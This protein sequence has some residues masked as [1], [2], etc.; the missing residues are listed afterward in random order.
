M[1]AIDRTERK[2]MS[3]GRWMRAGALLCC[4]GL[5]VAQVFADEDLDAELDAEWGDKRVKTYTADNPENRYEARVKLLEANR[6]AEAERCR[7]KS[8]GSRYCLNYAEEN[9]RKEVRALQSQ[10]EGQVEELPAP[11]VK[12]KG[13]GQK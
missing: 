7:V 2:L 3:T 13:F 6:D 4:V 11:K 5:C 12:S 1:A 10:F 8:G 9:F